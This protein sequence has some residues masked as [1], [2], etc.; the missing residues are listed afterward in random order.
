MTQTAR[1]VFSLF[2]KIALNGRNSIEGN[3]EQVFFHV[4]VYI[5]YRNANNSG[6]VVFFPV[7]VCAI[8]ASGLPGGTFVSM[9][10]FSTLCG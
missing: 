9:N 3:T 7:P 4:P 2:W 10:R 5:L 6:V 8:T 1:A